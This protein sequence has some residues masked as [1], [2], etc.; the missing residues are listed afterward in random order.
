[1]A[2]FD[3]FAREYS[4]WIERVNPP[5]YDALLD[6]FLPPQLDLAL[7]AGC[8]PGQLARYLARR[9]HTVLGLDISAAMIAIAREQ[10][11]FDNVHFVVGDL[12]WLSLRMGT[13]DFVGSDCALHDTPLEETLPALMRLLRPGGRL[14][15]RDLVTRCPTLTRL[16]VWQML[17]T[18]RQLPN[19]VRRFGPSDAKRV[20]AFELRPSWVRHRCESETTT[21]AQFRASYGRLLPG[22]RFMDYGWAMA[23]FWQA[24]T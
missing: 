15:V 20:A 21:P 3:P 1:M 8:G 19:Y 14:V 23:G 24:P 16:S 2:L 4:F 11:V 9:A 12:N 5:R 18:A 6:D 13:F 10:T 7:D 17:R 22:C